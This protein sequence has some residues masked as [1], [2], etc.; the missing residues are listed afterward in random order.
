MS[1]WITD[2]K[3]AGPWDFIPQGEKYGYVNNPRWTVNPASE[4][5][6]EPCGYWPKPRVGPTVVNIYGILTNGAT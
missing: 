3:G 1:D 5:I 4:V 2:N 6:H